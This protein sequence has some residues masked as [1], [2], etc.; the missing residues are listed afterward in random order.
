MAGSSLATAARMM[1]ETLVPESRATAVMAV[2]MSGVM[3]TMMGGD[4]G[5]LDMV[6]LGGFGEVCFDGPADGCTE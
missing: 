6:G 1:A 4:F 3:R 5:G 2:C